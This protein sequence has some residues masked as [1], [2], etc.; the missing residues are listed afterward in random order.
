MSDTPMNNT[1][2]YYFALSVVLFIFV[3]ALVLFAPRSKNF[4]N[5][6]DTYPQLANVYLN[7]DVV[8]KTF[9]KL[10]ASFD[11]DGFAEKYKKYKVFHE[12][13]AEPE[14]IDWPDKATATG[15]VKVL[16]LYMFSKIYSSNIDI[17]TELYAQVKSIKNVMAMF[18]VKLPISSKILPHCGWKE[19]SNSTLRFIYCFNSFCRDDTE[20]GIWVNG[21]TKIL[22]QGSAYVYDSS[23][24]HSIYNNT[25]DDVMFLCIDIERPLDASR[26]IST[27]SIEA[28]QN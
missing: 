22:T 18:F 23:K 7:E 12:P 5:I 20:C 1:F 13:R 11:D 9:I 6:N 16:P 4:Y 26:G 24:E 19:L 15:D 17:F 3:V 2:S 27:Y 25:F 21:E 8:D 28:A 10:G 14:W